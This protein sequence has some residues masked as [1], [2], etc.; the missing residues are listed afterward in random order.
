MSPFF[1]F[2]RVSVDLYDF[3]SFL[4]VSKWEINSILQMKKS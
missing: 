4:W 1:I 3:V 2:L